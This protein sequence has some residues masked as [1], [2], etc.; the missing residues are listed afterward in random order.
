M[1]S[2]DLMKLLLIFPALLLLW[3]LFLPAGLFYGCLRV[4]GVAYSVSQ[5]RSEYI[6]GIVFAIISCYATLA[7][8]ILLRRSLIRS[9]V[10]VAR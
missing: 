2:S 10:G 6:L 9:G 5:N 3:L 8:C 1:C 4:Y 7:L